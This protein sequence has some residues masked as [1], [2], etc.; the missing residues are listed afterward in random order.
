[1]VNGSSIKH[2]ARFSGEK[3]AA[4]LPFFEPKE[5]EGRYFTE[6]NEKMEREKG[7]YIKRER[8]T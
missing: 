5:F 3:C 4:G 1:V 2:F 7:I 8:E 6:L